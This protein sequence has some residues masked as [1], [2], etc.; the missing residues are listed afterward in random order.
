MNLSAVI[1]AGGKSARMG[2]DKARLEIGGRPL[3]ARQI[4]LVR[5]SGAREVFISGRAGEDYSKFE[6]PVLSDWFADAGPLAGI[7]RALATASFSRVLVVAVDMPNLTPLI[8]KQLVE[9]SGATMGVIPRV[10]GRLEPLAAIYPKS[11]GNL[12]ASLLNAGIYA[13]KTFAGRCVQDGLAEFFACDASMACHFDNW[14]LP[15]DVLSAV[16]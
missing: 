14:N 8:L 16:V 11:A 13:A 1:L 6:C 5:E 15:T 2:R 4:Q 7:E 10:D 3:L 12:A 9:R